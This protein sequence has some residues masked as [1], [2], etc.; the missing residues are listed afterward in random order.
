M[1]IKSE[2]ESEEL[3]AVF[4]DTVEVDAQPPDRYRSVQIVSG[5]EVSRTLA[6]GPQMFVSEDM[7]ASWSKVPLPEVSYPH[8]DLLATL[9][10]VP[11][12]VSGSEK[13]LT[14]VL[15]SRVSGCGPG[16][17]LMVTIAEERISSLVWALARGPEGRITVRVAFDYSGA[18]TD[19]TGP[20][21]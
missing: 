11:C 13:E 15:P 19:I 4:S 12:E 9:A 10:Q 8:Q 17:P 5:K 6:L 1:T 16:I 14:V 21:D 20:M 18:V 7:G 2:G 3:R